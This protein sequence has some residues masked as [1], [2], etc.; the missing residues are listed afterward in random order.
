MDYATGKQRKLGTSMT[1]YCWLISA[2]TLTGVATTT[3]AYE[4]FQGPTELIQYD[5]AR[6]YEG[7]TLFTPALGRNTYL[8]DMSGQVINMWPLPESWRDPMIREHAR[9]LEDGT[10]LRSGSSGNGSI[11]DTCPPES[12]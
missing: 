4:A 1:K 7:Y 6:A 10:L 9:L 11:P 12:R 3:L 5:P 2:I 8:I